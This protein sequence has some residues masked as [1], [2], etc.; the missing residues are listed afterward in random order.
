MKTKTNIGGSRKN[1]GQ[2]SYKFGSYSH[3]SLVHIWL[4]AGINISVL[5]AKEADK[6]AVRQSV[7]S[8]VNSME[9][10]VRDALE[11]SITEHGP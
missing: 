2:E 9:A 5:S 11:R 1:V 8:S 10:E 3:A 6:E 7:I 4:A